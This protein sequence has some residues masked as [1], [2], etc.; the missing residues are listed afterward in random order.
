MLPRRKNNL[1]K[2][3]GVPS[4]DRPALDARI[5][6]VTP[7]RAQRDLLVGHLATKVRALAHVESARA[8][9]SAAASGTFDLA[10]VPA[11]LTGLDGGPLA[12]ELISNSPG[13]GVVVIA[14]NPTLDDAIEALRSG[15]ADVVSTSLEPAEFLARLG[16]VLRRTQNARTREQ[17]INRLRRLCRRLNDSRQQVTKDIGGLCNDLTTAFGDISEQL[18]LVTVASEFNSIVRQ[19]LDIESLLRCVLEYLLT[20]TGPTNAA[21]FLPSTSGDFTLGAYVNYDGPR[22]SA[23]ILLDHLADSL[24]PRFENESD[25]VLLS[26]RAE[27]AA[28][29]GRASEWLGDSNLAAFSC[30]NGDECLAVVALFRDQNTPFPEPLIPVLRTLSDLFARQLARVVH[31]HHRHLPPGKW[32]GKFDTTRDDED[33]PD[34]DLAA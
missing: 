11:D 17:R 6:L 29:V 20:R 13:L 26:G 7:A 15:A 19:E 18:T 8:A 5:L 28:R 34:I 32:G 31:V 23:E 1:S 12:A 22:D 21:I 4:S 9:L 14:A 25:I 16:E 27:I 3:S 33:L 30:H 2:L 24:A 10:L